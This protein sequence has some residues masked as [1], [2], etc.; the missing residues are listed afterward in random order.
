MLFQHL[1]SSCQLLF[2]QQS[3]SHV[4]IYQTRFPLG[5]KL[6]N[7]KLETCNYT[8]ISYRIVKVTRVIFLLGFF[9]LVYMI[10]YFSHTRQLCL[11]I[12]L[13]CS[14]YIHSDKNRKWESQIAR[15]KV[16]LH[17]QSFSNQKAFAKRH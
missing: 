6:Q 9:L 2:Y 7:N 14:Y 5:I 3:L 16:G 10:D 8:T 11:A 17:Y 13:S 15:L 1:S 4:K 12:S